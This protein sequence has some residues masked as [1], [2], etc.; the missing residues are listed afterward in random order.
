MKS[1]FINEVELWVTNDTPKE[2]LDARIAALRAQGSRVI[3]FRSGHGDLTDL[4]GE[5]LRINKDLGR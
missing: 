5:L 3:V 2:S 1:N 4:T